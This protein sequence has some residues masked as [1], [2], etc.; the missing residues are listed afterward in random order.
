MIDEH[1]TGYQPRTEEELFG[2]S[3]NQY[4]DILSKMDAL[5]D[6]SQKLIQ[7]L[8]ANQ[9]PR[10]KTARLVGTH[11][12]I[13]NIGVADSV[14]RL[15][16]RDY[17]NPARTSGAKEIVIAAADIHRELALENQYPNVCQ[18]LKGRKFCQMAQIK[19][20]KVD[21][22]NPS[23]TTRFTFRIL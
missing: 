2:S 10:P 7:N 19:L 18:A 8:I 3:L 12:K 21:G 9:Q 11:S 4:R 5:V 1:T 6:G 17:V 20:V 16:L 14:R 22:P 23:S 15:A 13:R